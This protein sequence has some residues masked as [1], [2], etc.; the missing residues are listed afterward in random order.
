MEPDRDRF[1]H[2]RRTVNAT[3]RAAFTL[4]GA[5]LMAA[6]AYGVARHWLAGQPSYARVALVQ[7]CDLRAGA[8]RAEVDD[9]GV[10]LAISPTDIPL[11]QPLTLMVGSEG[12]EVSEVVV[13]IRGRN[14]DMGLNRTR[15]QRTADGRW[16]GETI[17]PI[18]SQRRMEW[19]AAVRLDGATRLEVPFAFHTERP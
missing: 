19:E 17:L 3:V 18:C 16:H 9:G 11:M 2:G 4:L 12:L 8:C 7:D 10:V 6:V 5:V 1:D 15:L 14:M 13:E